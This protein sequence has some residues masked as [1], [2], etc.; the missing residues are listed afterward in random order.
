MVDK[1]EHHP[2]NNKKSK[3]L[4]RL[5]Q[6]SKINNY[7]DELKKYTDM[8]KKKYPNAKETKLALDLLKSE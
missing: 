1:H 5:C 7:D 3:S 6:L 2:E 4:Y 8:L